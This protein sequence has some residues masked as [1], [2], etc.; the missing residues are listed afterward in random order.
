MA[1]ASRVSPLSLA[2]SRLSLDLGR[3]AIF[4]YPVTLGTASS[5]N[6]TERNGF[7]GQC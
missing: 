1:L 3:A 4:G 2:L 7:I 5:K 6:R